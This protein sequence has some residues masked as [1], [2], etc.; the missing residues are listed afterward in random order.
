MALD[1]RELLPPFMPIMRA[2][3]SLWGVTVETAM[4]DSFFC[5]MPWM[6]E[7]VGAGHKDRSGPGRN[8]RCARTGIREV[9]TALIR[10]CPGQ[11]HASADSN[12]MA[13]G[14]KLSELSSLP[15]YELEEVLRLGMLPKYLFVIQKMEK[16]LT[17]HGR[18]PKFW[19]DDIEEFVV[20]S[21]ENLVSRNFHIAEDLIE[22]FGGTEAASAQQRL[23]GQFGELLEVWPRIYEGGRQLKKR[24]GELGRE[25]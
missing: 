7:H 25:I 3:D 24:S 12:L 16:F 9:F 13:L 21:R 5:V 6:I 2:E 22:E 4:S 20:A 14:R 15:P 19:S 18:Q 11:A 1:N 23:I 8:A 10:L 17:K